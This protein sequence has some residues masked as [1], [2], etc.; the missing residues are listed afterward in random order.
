MT[1]PGGAEQLLAFAAILCVCVVI[2]GGAFLL[3]GWRID[4]GFRELADA[5]SKR[6]EAHARRQDAIMAKLAPPST[7]PPRRRIVGFI[8]RVGDEE[9]PRGE[10]A[11]GVTVRYEPVGGD[12]VTVGRERA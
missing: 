5:L 12:D 9:P 6:D 10:G 4:R 7:Q 1:A 3:A 11:S 2:I 8:P